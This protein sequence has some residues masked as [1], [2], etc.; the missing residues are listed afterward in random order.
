M[1]QASKIAAGWALCTMVVAATAQILPDTIQACRKDTDDARRL[2]CFDRETARYPMTSEH[3]FGLSP[4][5]AAATAPRVAQL[6]AKVVD[7]RERPHAGFIATL[8]NGQVWVQYETDMRQ[9]IHPGD[10][11]TIRPGALGSYWMSA[12]TGWSTRVR[13]A[14]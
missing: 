8:D 12:P 6:N 14:K 11:V 5:Q 3:G 4:S 13:R 10:V 9:D 2:A 7:L 1:Y